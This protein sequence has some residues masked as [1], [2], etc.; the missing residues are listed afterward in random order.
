LHC[1]TDKV[2]TSNGEAGGSGYY[3]NN[4]HTHTQRLFLFAPLSH[5]L[6]KCTFFSKWSK[7]TVTENTMKP[8]CFGK[9]QQIVPN[10]QENF[11]KFKSENI[12]L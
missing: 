6:P 7:E 12:I 10:E 11:L 3:L 9:V 2:K 4:S 1:V 5:N 8:I